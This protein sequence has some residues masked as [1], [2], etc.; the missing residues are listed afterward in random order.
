MLREFNRHQ[1]Q[2]FIRRVL[3]TILFL[4]SIVLSGGHCR[5]SKYGFNKQH[6]YLILIISFYSTRRCA[7]QTQAHQRNE[8]RERFSHM[9]N[10]KSQRIAILYSRHMKMTWISWWE[11]ET[12]KK[13]NM[14]MKTG[15]VT[16]LNVKMTM[17]RQTSYTIEHV[18]TAQPDNTHYSH[19]V[20][21]CIMVKIRK[22]V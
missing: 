10:K 5:H 20:W 8:E 15:Q 19:D 1:V 4:L 9:V 2:S 11:R 22:K 12:A 18:L 3:P 13:L 7:H 21:L 6:I 17:N 14:K 16:V